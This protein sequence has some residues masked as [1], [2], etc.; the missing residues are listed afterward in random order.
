MHEDE[1]RGAPRCLTTATAAANEWE[2]LGEQARLYLAAGA[3]KSA[4]DLLW[5][6]LVP[7]WD[8][9]EFPTEAIECLC[10]LL[11]ACT[12]LNHKDHLSRATLWLRDAEARALE[13]SP[14]ARALAALSCAHHEMGTKHYAA[15]RRR[16]AEIESLADVSLCTRARIALLQGRLAASS[17]EDRA[18]ERYG[19]RA[20]REAELAS[21]EIRKADAISLLA[22]LA[23][24]RGSLDEAS[25]LYGKAATYYWR[26]GD[27]GGLATVQLNRA[28]TVGLIGLLRDSERLFQ[29]ALQHAVS[30][31]REG[32]ALRARLGLGWVAVRGGDL[33]GARARLLV[34][35][36]AARRLGLTRIEGMALEYLTAAYTL[37]G[38]LPKAGA[39]LRL[40]LR[41]ATSLAPMSDLV[42]EF[43][44]REAMLSLAN[45]QRKL[46][47]RQAREA[48]RTAR[49][50][51]MPWEEAQAR[52]ILAIAY[53]RAG[54][55]R[56]ARVEFEKARVLLSAIGEQLERQVAEAWLRTLGPARREGGA[57]ED[58]PDWMHFWL[59]HPL[60]GPRSYREGARPTPPPVPPQARSVACHPH[61]SDL[62]FVT[63]TPAVL[64][65][66]RAVET[67]A[68]GHIPVLIL[69][70]TGTGKDL[71]ARGLHLLS[72][73]PGSLVP[74]N[75]AA[76]RKDLFVAE[77]FGARKGAY[78]GAL[79][80][81]HGLIEEAEHGTLFF[82]EIADLEPEAQGYLLRFLDSGE[83]R[84]VGGTQSRQIKTRV[85][86]ATCRDLRRR[87]REGFF[88]DDLYARLAGLVV[89]VA[90]LRERPEDVG[91]IALELWS[92]EGGDPVDGRR[93]LSADVISA[94]KLSRW[95]GNVREF[96]HTLARAV[97]LCRVE[98]TEAARRA[99]LGAADPGETEHRPVRE[100]RAHLDA[101]GL[102]AAL[103]AANGRISGAARI[104]GISRS[105]AYRLYRR[106][107]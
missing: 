36:R 96:R 12:R 5:P 107:S 70:E 64:K 37:A 98:G 8:Q 10:L 4:H 27:L 85:I 46:A 25:A 16:L 42:L 103:A 3:W 106:L 47:M 100:H 66:L 92:R 58:A 75:C 69:G 91:P 105:H 9:S 73:H 99:L 35:W 93:I 102:R 26:S 39:A 31:G 38:A 83:V 104:L 87:V 94:L 52:A 82:D 71:I 97:L 41:L 51:G 22:I 44:I 28:W 86:A 21:N 48:R 76:A 33:P 18:A 49:Q 34:V 95:A 101:E 59:D 89:E 55:K 20:A 7:H 45:G 77:L 57:T 79:E 14:E 60:L 40:G 84:P 65:T 13:L 72:G 78:T 17:G 15:A 53:V 80:H 81:R 50:L 19:L 43:R 67:Y 29:E 1:L 56:D 23:R 74:V 54:R 61:W 11:G 6:H 32:T 63:Q 62:G 68:P 88:R 30:L 2:A 90:P 24:R